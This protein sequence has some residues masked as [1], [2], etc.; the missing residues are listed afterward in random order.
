MM[1]HENLREKKKRKMKCG[2]YTNFGNLFTV[3][4]NRA[5]PATRGPPTELNGKGVN[6]FN[7]PHNF[8]SPSAS[9]ENLLDG[10][11]Y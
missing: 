1:F 7:S 11:K 8:G 9:E 6:K 4:Q 3:F 5:G 10:A 2:P